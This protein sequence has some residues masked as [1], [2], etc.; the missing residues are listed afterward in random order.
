[1]VT[2]RQ[3]MTNST[4]TRSHL[5]V[6]VAL[7]VSLLALVGIATTM[8]IADDA[9]GRPCLAVLAPVV[10]LLIA[11]GNRLVAQP[12]PLLDR[13]A[14]AAVVALAGAATM[15]AW[16]RRDQPWAAALL[17]AAALAFAGE[18]L[19][20][21]RLVAGGVVLL[22]LAAI[23]TVL[24]T[25]SE[26]APFALERQPPPPVAWAEAVVVLGLAALA[27]LFRFYALNR[28][29][30]YFE[31]EL[32]P[33]MV[34]ATNL[35]GMLPANAGM[36]GPWAPLGLLY[37]LPIYLMTHLAG[38]TVLAVRLASAIIAILTIAAA[39]L[40]AREVAGRQPALVAAAILTL[41]PLQIGWGRSDVHPHGV[42]AWPGLLLAWATLR[43]LSKRSWGWCAAVAA[44]M[45]LSWFQYPSG[46]LVV[47][48][49]LLA[50][51][52]L[53]ISGAGAVRSLGYRLLLLAPGLAVWA[54]GYPLQTWL[55]GGHARSPLGYLARLG[56]R[57]SGT[58]YGAPAPSLW[59]YAGH[60][61]DNAVDI[62][63]GLFADVPHLH[64]QTFLPQIGG[65]PARA[66]PFFVAGLAL[67][68]LAGLFARRLT[69]ST[70]VLGALLVTTVAPSLLSDLGN[71][72]R[73]AVFFLV[74][75]I[76]AAV[77]L[78]QV[79]RAAK[80]ALGPRGGHA[81]V[82]AVGIAFAVWTAVAASLW[83]SGHPYRWGMPPEVEI[84]EG[85][86]RR[87]TPGSLVLAGIWDGYLPGKLTYLLLDTLRRPDMQP[88][89][90]LVTDTGSA[91]WQRLATRPTAAFQELATRPW[92]WWWSGM[93]RLLPEPRWDLGWR[94][95]VYVIEQ[96]ENTQPQLERIRDWCPDVEVEDISAGTQAKH[97]F[98]LAVCANPRLAPP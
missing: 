46:Q 98:L 36:H 84:V 9:A 25:R 15:A 66:L 18:L 86:A 62:A 94:R 27:A 51:L 81:A 88:M 13:P 89:A 96:D 79:V 8:A 43:M 49:P 22:A 7:A 55:A 68:G 92:Y 11:G 50:L 35:G 67:L 4:P 32:S 82:A 37:Y 45:A 83:F 12:W 3:P 16:R 85:V 29:L 34:G 48:V 23:A 10:N 80:V 97:E 70:A 52:G 77:A 63:T 87:L 28:V 53:A 91:L 5:P 56:Q 75:E 20:L 41:D 2:S 21:H 59:S 40:L 47:F 33:Y 54:L 42:T 6:A 58:G 65:I 72:K 78:V 61:L 30:D 24:A 73:A 74:L 69:A 39:W 76:V 1:M 14:I 19:L 95:V 93:D 64:H 38:S 90:W 60:L 31:G 71:V 44:L 17:A 26:A 57:F